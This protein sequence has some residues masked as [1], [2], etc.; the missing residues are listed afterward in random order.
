MIDF[1][2]IS[3]L[4]KPNLYLNFSMHR[5]SFTPDINQTLSSTVGIQWNCQIFKKLLPYVD[6]PNLTLVEI[7]QF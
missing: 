4:T 6:W 2:A 1:L 7:V 5:A 3:T